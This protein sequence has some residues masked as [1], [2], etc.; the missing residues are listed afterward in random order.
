MSDYRF[1]D[2]V[3]VPFPFTDQSSTKQRPAVAVSSATYHR[4]RP[5]VIVMAVTSQV[6]TPLDFGET[7][8]SDWQSANLLKPSSVKPIIATIEQHLVRKQL[9][10][11]SD[12]DQK[13][14]RNAIHHIV[15]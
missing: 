13:G 8:L 4:R 10:R 7:L 12:G 1:G 5:D 6:R 9:G 15:G 2:V 11:L 14:L 3:L